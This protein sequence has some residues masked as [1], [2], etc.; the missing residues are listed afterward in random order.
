[1]ASDVRVRFAP[2][3][4]GY[5]HV[6][7]ARTALYDYLIARHTGGT[8]I[9]RI[10]DTDRNRLNEGAVDEIYAS[11]RWLGLDWDEGPQ[12][13]GPYGP[14]IQ[15]ERTAL[16][17]THTDELLA[18]GCAYRCF[19]T[20]E[21]L[22]EIRKE[23]EKA[24][25]DRMGY[26]RHCRELPADESARRAAAG[27][28]HVVRFRVPLD[29]SV[30]FDD[31][32]RGRIE[33]R[34]NELEDQVLLKSDGFPTYHLAHLVDDHH[35]RISHVLRGEEWI[36]S[37][38]LHILMYEA[39]GWPGPKFAHLP[40]ILSP[41][42]GKL[43]KRKGAASVM[44]Y[45]EAGFM[46]EALVN[47]LALVG[48]APGDNREKMSRQELIEAFTLERVSPKAAVLD[49]QKL[50][51]LN[52]QYLTEL[53]VEAVADTVLAG[54]R[55]MGVVDAT[56]DARD[57][58]LHAIIT[59]MKSRCRRVT[60]I[61]PSS[62]YFFRDPDEYEEKAARKHFTPEASPLLTTLC[63]LLE[64]TPTFDTHALEAIYREYAEKNGLSVGKIIHPTR[65]ATS[66]VSFG[67][68]LFE[69]M[70]LLGK[71]TVLRRMRR[72]A[73]W[74]ENSRNQRSADGRGQAAP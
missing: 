74:I 55:E 34:S 65:L 4:T 54:W 43:S 6:G 16:Y 1:M 42:G 61:A 73:E 15:S 64:A 12:V 58:R 68:G 30:A 62:G 27:E 41:E 47:I 46:P 2:S 18:K 37:T 32:V 53:P 44:D 72:A 52:G 7:N 10:E 31:I 69:M 25:A 29:R 17:R 67:P 28:R 9:L 66:G 51:W 38:P 63:G 22:G 35:M 71:E 3:P 50:E 48:W 8:F 20:S 33:Y 45:K 40:V 5:L 21:R 39:F 56:A 13:G 60:E 24:K 36:P 59:Q 19:C 49:H 26:D 11:L 57:P 70:E 14:Y 23:Q